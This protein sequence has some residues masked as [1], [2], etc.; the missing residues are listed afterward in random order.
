[1]A[2]MM[3]NQPAVSDDYSLVF[4]KYTLTPPWFAL[5]YRLHQTL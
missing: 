1:M 5:S 4:G 3:L 2:F